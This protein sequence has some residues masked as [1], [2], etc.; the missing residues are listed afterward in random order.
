MSENE[1]TKHFFKTGNIKYFRGKA[2]NVVL[3]A[4]GRKKDPV[5]ANAYLA[6]E[7]RIHRSLLR[8]HV[9]KATAVQ[10]DWNRQRAADVEANGK[11]RVFGI[12]VKSATTASYEDA[13]SG[14]LELM[15]FVIDAGPLRTLLNTEARDAREFLADNPDGRV[16][17]EIWVVVTAELARHWKSAVSTSV[18]ADA[19][20][21]ALEV[22]ATSSSGGQ[23]TMVISPNTTFAYL[24]YK[25]KDWNKGKT[26]I[27]LMEDDRKGMG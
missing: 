24:L 1:I 23:E 9:R 25:V 12:K 8:G 3:G 20:D 10:I 17:G 15:K 7:D 19:G 22:T 18:A 27:A 21:A 13:R 16:V 5:G 26:E 11:L 14:D 6:V 2:E 4:Y